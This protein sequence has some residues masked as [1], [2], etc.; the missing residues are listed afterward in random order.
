MNENFNY[1][2]YWNNRLNRNF[3]I[4][5]VGYKGLGNIYNRHMYSIR[6][7]I[8]NYLISMLY[9]NIK[10]M[11]ILEFGPGTG[12]FT[13]FFYQRKSNSYSAVDISRKSINELKKKYKGYSFIKGDICNSKN[14]FQKRYDLIFSADVLLHLTDEEKYKTTINNIS[15]VVKDDGYIVIF[16]PISLID[17]KSKA[18]HNIIR[19]VKYVKKIIEDNGLKIEKMMPAF[20]LMNYPFDKKLLQQNGEVLNQLFDL[21]KKT[22]SDKNIPNT[23]KELLAMLLSK[24]EKI[25][26]TNNGFGVSEKVLILKKV[27]NK[28]RV[29]LGIKNI[30][31]TEKIKNEVEPLQEQLLNNKFNKILLETFEKSIKKIT[32]L[33]TCI[34]FDNYI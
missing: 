10:D 21:I 12:I 25:C 24:R 4:E 18:T 15:K 22:F 26:L 31:N 2:L 8:L 7:E 16:D 14:Y 30:W 9:Q 11:D 6:L 1:E 5:G 34:D 20:F 3:S 23:S 33:E 28:K 19:D 32:K 13:E 29:Q 27:N 17:T